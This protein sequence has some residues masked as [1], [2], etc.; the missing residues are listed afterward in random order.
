MPSCDVIGDDRLSRPFSIQSKSLKETRAGTILITSRLRSSA[1][2]HTVLTNRRPSCPRALSV[3]RT[4]K[5]T[6]GS[7]R[8][9]LLQ[10]A[11]LLALLS[12]SA[13][14]VD[15]PRYRG[16]RLTASNNH[17]SDCDKPSPSP[18]EADDDYFPAYLTPEPTAAAAAPTAGESELDRRWLGRMSMRYDHS[19]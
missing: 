17:S 1:G 13:G 9:L 2:Y 19:V 11:C 4:G 3:C 7:A 8:T 18:A 16:N 12:C 6:G 10:S 14:A 5:K 15:A